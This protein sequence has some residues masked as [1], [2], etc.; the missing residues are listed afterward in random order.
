MFLFDTRTAVHAAPSRKYTMPLMYSV[1]F[2][3]EAPLADSASLFSEAFVD[4]GVNTNPSRDVAAYRP[5]RQLASHV[6]RTPDCSL[7][8]NASKARPELIADTVSG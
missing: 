8:R 2:C 7:A 3:S 1:F 4:S 6:R 5:T